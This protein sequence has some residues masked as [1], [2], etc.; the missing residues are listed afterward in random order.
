MGPDADTAADIEP[1]GHGETLAPIARPLELVDGPLDGRT[2]ERMHRW[3]RAANYLAV[4]QIYLMGNPL[5]REP[6]LADDVKPRLLGHFGTVPGLNLVWLHA[7]RAIRRARPRRGVRRRPGPRRPRPQRLRLAR[8]HLLRAVQ[9]RHRR[10][11]PVWQHFFRQFSFPGGVP[12]HCAPETPGSFHEGGELGYSLLHAFGAVLDNPDLVGVL[13]RRRRRGRDRPAGRQLARAPSSWTRRATAPCCR[14]WRL[15]EYK[16]ANPTLLARIPAERAGRPAARLR[17][18]AAPSSP[19]TTRPRCTRRWPRPSTPAWTRSRR[20]RP[21]RARGER[22]DHRRSGALADDR[23]AHAEGLDRARR[24]STGSRSRARSA[25]TRCRCPRARTD[26]AHR[27]VLRGVAAARTGPRS[28]STTTGRLVA[29][30]PGR[31][32]R[33]AS[34]G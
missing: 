5:L 32:P 22:A 17:L 10:R 2:L 27:A 20:S 16:I 3:W 25:P 7:N 15:N 30:L 31:W 24:S 13:R 19:A 14:S 26:A 9:P 4:G 21:R 8:G 18:R 1:T 33:R 29:E 12:S 11:S 6:L 28:C 23:A 34:A